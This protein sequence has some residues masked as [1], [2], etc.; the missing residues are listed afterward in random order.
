MTREVA[1]Y[2]KV[3]G[4]VLVSG[5]CGGG[6]HCKLPAASLCVCVCVCV[7]MINCREQNNLLRVIK[8]KEI[9]EI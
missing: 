6:S 9:W 1:Q 2:I 5:G 7:C 3:C 8:R 4:Y